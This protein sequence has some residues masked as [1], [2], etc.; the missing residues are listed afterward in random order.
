MRSFATGGPDQVQ[1][2]TELL[3]SQ[4]MEE[5]THPIPLILNYCGWRQG[6]S[7]A[8]SNMENT[9]RENTTGI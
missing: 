8:I 4:E 7:S 6:N 3:K 2:K 9:H 5:T 1:K